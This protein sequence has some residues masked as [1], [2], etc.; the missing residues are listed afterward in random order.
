MT[1]V[2][3]VLGQKIYEPT[4]HSTLFPEPAGK[5]ETVRGDDMDSN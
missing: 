5:Q 4:N 2:L 3:S 1:S